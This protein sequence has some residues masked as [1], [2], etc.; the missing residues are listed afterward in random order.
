MNL[1][2]R[3][4]TFG[5][6]KP[7]YLGQ[8]LERKSGAAAPDPEAALKAA[9]TE[10]K[11]ITDEVKAAAEKAQKEMKESG[12]LK[13]EVKKSIDE[14]LLKQVEAQNAFSA[15]LAEIEQKLVRRGAANDDDRRVKT[16]GAQVIS[17]ER[18]KAFAE[19]KT[20]GIVTLPVEMKATV[21]TGDLTDADII[22]PDRQIPMVMRT[23]QR[24]FVRDL[25]SPG[26]TTS[27][28]LQYVQQTGF[29]N[30]ADVVSENT[31]KP[32]SAIDF[33]LKSVNVATIAHIIKASKQ[34]LDDFAAL[35]SIIDD[36]LRYGLK[37]VEE[38]QILFGDGTGINLHGIVPQAT[39]FAP[40]FAVDNQTKIDD[41]RLAVLQSELAE[42][43]AT[44][45][46]L[47]PTDWASIELTK[48][49]EGAYIFAS[50]LR[51]AGPTLWGLPVVP[52]KA[53]DVGEFLTGAFQLGA[54]LFDRE[55]ANVQV[56]TQN[57]DD[58][59]KNMI[60]LRA[61]E[62]LALAVKRPE[63]FVTGEFSDAT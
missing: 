1:F 31:R 63:A 29:T 9:A 60:T 23:R 27:N 30:N 10:L 55:D 58:F 22:A 28:S 39:A 4:K 5:M 32:T 19:A 51:L 46:V 54:Q 2:L 12:E 42:Y 7:I 62:R 44:A 26:R 53:M 47:H 15:R 56:A 59:V 41:L 20:R 17:H 43:P 3:K 35:Q 21:T 11:R 49:T 6:V 52:T 18:F 38:Q 34:L 24:L 40:A 45:F 50:P 14:L 57:E 61:E 16:I 33:T 8:H 36:E 13:L 48:T 25:I 37:F